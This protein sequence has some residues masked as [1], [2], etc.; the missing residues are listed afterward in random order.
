MMRL[1]GLMLCLSLGIAARAET[2]VVC[3]GIAHYADPR[4]G[5]LTQPETDAK[6]MAVFFKRGTDNVI[7]LTGKYATKA[8]ILRSLRSQC[9]R[10]APGDRII[11]YFSGHGYP[12]GF[13][14]YDMRDIGGGLTY[15]EVLAII[16]ASRATDKLIFADACNSGAIRSNREQSAPD[17]GNTLMFLSSRDKEA[18][19]ERQF[20]ANGF[21]TKCLLRGLRGAADSDRDKTITATEIF[22]YVKEGVDTLSHGRQHPV[23]WG[24]FP[25]DLPIV[26]YTSR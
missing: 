11:F 24:T 2:Y 14:P 22:K 20:I 8:A 18:S 17:P 6:A 19:I 23:M 26:K 16:N 1:I 21:F 10:T 4:A 12:G 7:T 15:D 9:G 13:C 3:V 25:D 5:D